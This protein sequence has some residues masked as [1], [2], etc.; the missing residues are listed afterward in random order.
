MDTVS[1]EIDRSGICLCVLCGLP[2]AGKSTLVRTLPSYTRKKGWRIFILS[3]DEIIP[4]EAYE[5]R[6]END[7]LMDTQSSWKSYRQEVLQCLDAFLQSQNAPVCANRGEAWA[8]FERVAQDQQVLKASD[9]SLRQ[10]SH[11][12]SEPLFVLLD[13][14]F[15][16]PSMR[17]EVYQ[18]A[19]KHSLGFCQI[20]LRCPLNVCLT[21]NRMRGCPL[22]DEVIVEMAKRIEPPNPLKNTWEQKSL[23]LTSTIDFSQQD[24]EL[25]IQLL[26]AALENPLTPIQDNTEQKEADRQSC[27]SSI[28]HQADQACRRLVSQA[29]RDAKECKWTASNM[30]SLAA[31]LN[32]LKTKFLEDLRKQVLQGYPICPGETINVE[33]VV[34]RAVSVFDQEKNYIMRK[35]STE[36]VKHL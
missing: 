26:G 32:Q 5:L 12:K 19:K 9:D 34:S 6:K 17:Y 30:K 33:L 28:V 13:D 27:A 24:I 2:A 22:P 18:L 11:I 3:Y 8:R 15:Y 36:P 4:E 23:T 25:L 10:M 35:Y 1:G 16:Y 21:R 29:M 20:Y 14:N 31:E 7:A